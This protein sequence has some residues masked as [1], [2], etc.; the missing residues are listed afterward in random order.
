[1]GI[2][3]ARVSSRQ[4][5]VIR[6]IMLEDRPYLLHGLRLRLPRDVQATYTCP[7]R[8]RRRQERRRL[9]VVGTQQGSSPRA[10]GAARF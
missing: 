2:A 7:Q 8:Q 4:L 5:E 9:R 1:M 6:A 10:S 3:A